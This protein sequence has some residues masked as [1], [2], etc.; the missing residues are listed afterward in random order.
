MAALTLEHIEKELL[1][2]GDQVIPGRL[3]DYRVWLAAQNSLL[4]GEMQR[5]LAIKAPA[6]N[7][8]REKKNSDKATDRQWQ[9]TELGQRETWLKWELK[10]I[11]GIAS[12]INT[13]IN[14]ANEES[15]NRY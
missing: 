1:E 3:G 4:S 11:A 15:R 2:A 14:L 6:W 8:M 9:A 13:K 5:I 7:A 12:A 10:R